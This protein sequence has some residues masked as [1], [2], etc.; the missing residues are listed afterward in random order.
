MKIA[1]ILG[2]AAALA[3]GA[4]TA[5]GQ[6]FPADDDWTALACGDRPMFDGVADE[7]Q[8]VDERDIV[9]DDDAPAGFHALDDDFLY[10]RLRLEADPVQASGALRPFAWGMGFDL[11]GDR[12]TY[13]LLIMATGADQTVKLFSN[14]TTTIANSPADPADQPAVASYPFDDAGRSAAAG[15]SFGGD[16]DRFLDLAVPWADL[17]PL[18]LSPATTIAVWAATSTNGDRMDADLA[19]HDGA[20]GEPTLDG[21]ASD[22]TTPGAGGGGGGGGGVAGDGELT[23]G[24]GCASGRGAPAGAAL[25]ILVVLAGRVRSAACAPTRRSRRTRSA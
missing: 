7:P 9:G 22:E 12:T 2:F 18:G 13:E 19:C 15:S 6:V 20:S 25:W 24:G 23:G 1:A 16:A 17:E 5:A 8:A 14:D 11:D 10:L 3:G 4:A 21:T